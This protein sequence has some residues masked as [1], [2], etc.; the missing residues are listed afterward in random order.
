[1]ILLKAT[2]E[3]SS[4]PTWTYSQPMPRRLLLAG[5]VAGDAVAYMIELSQL[6]DVDVDHLAGLLA[7]ISAG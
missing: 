4:M 7:F 5:A 6:F 2:R 3:A 1:M